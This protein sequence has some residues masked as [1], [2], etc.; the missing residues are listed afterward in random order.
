MEIDLLHPSI[1]EE[2]ERHKKHRL[3]Q[4][5][6]SF[7]MDVRCSSCYGITTV[8]SHAQTVITCEGCS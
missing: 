6:N 7:F 5:P 8:F 4:N 2:R 3:V 1:E